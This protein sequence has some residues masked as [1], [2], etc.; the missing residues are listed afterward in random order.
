MLDTLGLKF[1]RYGKG[2]HE[3]YRH[4]TTGHSAVVPQ[5]VADDGTRK[6]IWEQATGGDDEKDEKISPSY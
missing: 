5:D 4:P 2:S 1:E 3:I 6:S